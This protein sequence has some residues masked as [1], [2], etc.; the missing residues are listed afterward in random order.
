MIGPTLVRSLHHKKYRDREGLFLVQGRKL[1]EELLASGWPVRGVL[2]TPEAAAA[3]DLSGVPVV[4]R[5]M[6]ELKRLGTLTTGNELVAVVEKPEKV[7]GGPPTGAELVLALD[8]VSDPGNMGTMLR[9]ADWFGVHRVVCGAGCVEVWNPKCVQA[10]MGSLFRVR[11]EEASLPVL[12]QE[13]ATAGTTIYLA[14]MSGAPVHQLALRRPSVL[15]MGSE[16]HGL[17][18]EVRALPGTRVSVPGRGGAE[19]LN[20]AMAASALCLEFFRQAEAG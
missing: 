13:W 10:T 16:S 8:G 18:P 5:P 7:P 14:D 1:V 20:V 4:V 15:V 19:S 17:S 6:Q 12:L 11:V 2:A 9:I 3:S